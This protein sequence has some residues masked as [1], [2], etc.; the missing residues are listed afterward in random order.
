MPSSAVFQ[1]TL[2]L[3]GIQGVP[4]PLSRGATTH[5]VKVY[6]LQLGKIPCI[7]AVLDNLVEQSLLPAQDIIH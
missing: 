6:D 4:V 1:K 7:Q 2:S 3:A 5:H